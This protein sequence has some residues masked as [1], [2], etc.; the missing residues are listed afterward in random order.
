MISTPSSLVHYPACYWK[1][2]TSDHFRLNTFC[3]LELHFM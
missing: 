1:F 3:Y 2:K